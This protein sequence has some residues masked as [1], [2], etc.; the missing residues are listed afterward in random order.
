M[1]SLNKNVNIG[2]D[3]KNIIKKKILEGIDDMKNGRVIDGEK[4]LKKLNQIK[5]TIN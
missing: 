1:E 5:K 4:F 3:E 2:E